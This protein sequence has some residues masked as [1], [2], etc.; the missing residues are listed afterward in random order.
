MLHKIIH[1]NNEERFLR[2]VIFTDPNYVRDDMT[3]TSFAFK[4][5]KGEAGLS[6]DIESMTTYEKSIT[7]IEKYRLFAVIVGQIRDLGLDCEHKPEE[8]NYAHA[9]I[10]GDI[11][12]PVRSKLAKSAV[13]I[14]YPPHK[15]IR[16]IA[17]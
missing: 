7:N 2:R 16:E 6:G 5:R 1:L 11:S 3:V 12:N 9:E 13:Y 17:V 10:I 15:P 14:L 8:N 4:L